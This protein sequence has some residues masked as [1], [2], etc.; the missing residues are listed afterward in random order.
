MFR[1]A[2]GFIDCLKLRRTLKKMGVNV[3]GAKFMS[4]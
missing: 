3:K 4:F 2:I 1:K